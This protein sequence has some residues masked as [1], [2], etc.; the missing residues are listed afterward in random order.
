M[1]IFRPSPK[2]IERFQKDRPKT[3]GGVVWTRCLLP[4]HFCSIR[5][6]KTYKL[7]MRRKVTKIYFGILRKAHAYLQTIIKAPL[8]CKRIHFK[9]WEGLPGQ[10]TYYKSGTKH[11]AL[12]TTHH[13]KSK[14]M[15]LRFSSKRRICL[16]ASIL[17]I[18]PI[19][20]NT[21][22]HNNKRLLLVKLR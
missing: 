3:V 12:R 10:G 11:H 13:G 22:T 5:S 14:T 21:H 2:H 20:Y 4:I 8:S 1:R 17:L 18:S 6:L 9:L 7:K 15:P 19:L 16:K